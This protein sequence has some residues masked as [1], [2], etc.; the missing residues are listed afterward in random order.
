MT[1]ALFYNGA[2]ILYVAAMVAYLASLLIR[3]VSVAKTGGWI[4]ASAFALHTLAFA[5][6][7]IERG[8]APVINISE[9]LS[10]FA[11]AA[12]GAYLAIQ[13]KG[14][15]KVLGA[16]ITPVLVI[17]MIGASSGYFGSGGAQPLAGGLVTVHIVLCIAAEALFLMA[18]SAG[19]VYLI[20]NELLKHRRIGGISRV[21]PS[22]GDL[23]RIN[24]LCLVVGF[25]LLTL[26]MIVGSFWA[27][28]VWGP[29][30]NGDP[31]QVVTLIIWV[32]YAFL[33][34][35]RVAIGWNGRK[36]AIG[37]VAAILLVWFSLMG[38]SVFL[39]STHH[40]L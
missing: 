20:Q 30:W 31:K 4:L 13:W 7:S 40:F 5:V 25:V 19:L 6:R 34:H 35:Q 38:V 15:V 11:W 8:G 21:L 24:G 29:V 23:D 33:I 22:L 12:A 37:S 27:R 18:G 3:R 16:F 1:D 10:F 28:I 2:L 32:V 39:K 14:R 26:G 17:L 36:A 9:A